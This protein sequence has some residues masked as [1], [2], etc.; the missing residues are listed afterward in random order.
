ML[1]VVEISG[2]KPAHKKATSPTGDSR[3]FDS[4]AHNEMGGVSIARNVS[5]NTSPSLVT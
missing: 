1:A 3:G 2:S 5:C 4:S